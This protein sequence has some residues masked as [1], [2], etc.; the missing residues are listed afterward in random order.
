MFPGTSISEHCLKMIGDMEQFINLILKL[1]SNLWIDLILQSLPEL[2]MNEIHASLPGL[3]NIVVMVEGTLKT[4]SMTAIVRK[5]S[6]SIRKF[7]EKKK[8]S[9]EESQFK[10][11]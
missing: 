4:N 8:S 3:M 1:H 5:S 6:S 9:S 11:S 7:K 2:L 10:E